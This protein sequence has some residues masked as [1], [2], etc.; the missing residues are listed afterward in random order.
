MN[1]RG[2]NGDGSGK[3]DGVSDT[4]DIASMIIRGTEKG[5]LL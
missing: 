1:E 4:M 3:V 5:D 2:A